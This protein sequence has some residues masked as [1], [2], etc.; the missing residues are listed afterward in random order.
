MESKPEEVV[1]GQIEEAKGDEVAKHEV[2][3]GEEKEVI[4]EIEVV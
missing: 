1:K 4:N 2:L 3:K